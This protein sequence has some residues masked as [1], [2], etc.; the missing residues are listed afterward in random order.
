MLSTETLCTPVT[1][2]KTENPRTLLTATETC[3]K[4]ETHTETAY[5]QRES[6]MQSGTDC[7]TAEL[8]QDSHTKH[9]AHVG[10]HSGV[11]LSN[12]E[13]CHDTTTT[14][15]PTDTPQDHVTMEHALHFCSLKQVRLDT[16]SPTKVPTTSPVKQVELDHVSTC[17][18]RSRKQVRFPSDSSISVVHEIVAWN[19]AYRAARKGPWELYARNRAHFRRKIDNLALVIEPCLAKKIANMHLCPYGT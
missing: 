5:G 7:L 11:C 1:K 8:Y 17:S 15:T 16:C 18:Y 2:P 12:E 19:Y 10:V 9:N 3:I 4:P 13:T 14:D 6:M